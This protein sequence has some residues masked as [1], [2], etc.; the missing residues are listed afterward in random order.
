MAQYTKKDVAV[1]FSGGVD[2]SLLLKFACREAEQ[3]GTKVYAVIVHTKL[4]PL[5]ELEE[6]AV[7]SMIKKS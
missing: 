7:A 2:S 5:G 6:G 1:A 4:H 3:N